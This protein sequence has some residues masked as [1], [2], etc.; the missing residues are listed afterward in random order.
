MV[1]NALVY[2]KSVTGSFPNE[3]ELV[4]ELISTYGNK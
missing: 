2:S 4:N 1:D 3:E